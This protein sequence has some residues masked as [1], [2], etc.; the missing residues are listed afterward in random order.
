MKIDK[1]QIEKM[2]QAMCGFCAVDKRCVL[3][4]CAPCSEVASQDC[5]CK[6]SAEELIHKGYGKVS[7]YKA[8]IERLRTTLGQCNTELNSALESLKSQCREIGALKAGTKQAKIEV[9]NK[10]KKRVRT[11]YVLDDFILGSVVFSKDIDE[12]IKE[13]QMSDQQDRKQVIIEGLITTLGYREQ[14][15]NELEAEL[16]TWKTR[17]EVAERRN[18]YLLKKLDEVQNG[19]DKG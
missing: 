5:T 19:E 15:I 2:A 16:I 12:L 6:E 9:L 18:K 11:S 14:R 17:A 4:C 7:E 1:E 10:L 3:K 8:E 13:V